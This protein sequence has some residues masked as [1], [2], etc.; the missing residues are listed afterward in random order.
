[1]PDIEPVRSISPNMDD[2]KKDHEIEHYESASK[3][4]Q[5]EVGVADR[6]RNLSAKYVPLHPQRP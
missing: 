5:V 4:E 6:N 2:T 1:M 3:T